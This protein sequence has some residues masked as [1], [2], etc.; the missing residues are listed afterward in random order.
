MGKLI[1]LIALIAVTG[2]AVIE[3]PADMVTIDI[4]LPY[5]ESN[6]YRQW[7]ISYPVAQEEVACL[8][9]NTYFEARGEEPDG[10]FAVAEVVMNRVNHHNFPNTICGV[11]KAGRYNSWDN[12]MPIK[13]KCA[14]HWYCDR[15]SDKINNPKSYKKSLNIAKE[16]LY[17]TDYKVVVEYALF[18]HADHITPYWADKSKLITSIGNHVFYY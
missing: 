17:N 6:P 7:N 8:A 10:Q 2:A 14:F 4:D 1:T 18:Y 11:V 15:L 12:S 5:V 3:Q 9:L 13:D 16:I